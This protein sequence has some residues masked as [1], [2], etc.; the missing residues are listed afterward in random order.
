MIVT[1]IP[2]MEWQSQWTRMKWSNIR[3]SMKYTQADNEFTTLQTRW[4]R[5]KR[6]SFWIIK[7]HEMDGRNEVLH[8]REAHFIRKRRT[9]WQI[10]WLDLSHVII[11]AHIRALLSHI[12]HRTILQFQIN[13]FHQRRASLTESLL[14]TIKINVGRHM[15][16]FS[17]CYSAIAKCPSPKLLLEIGFC[18]L[19]TKALNN[20]FFAQ[21]FH[22]DNDCSSTNDVQ[23]E[24][25]SINWHGM[26][27]PIFFAYVD[28]EFVKDLSYASD[29]QL[30]SIS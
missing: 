1:K 23:W 24:N 20:N 4:E 12:F 30:Y 8:S 18:S 19:Q 7:R 25:S 3:I 15:L 14:R 9:T 22:R 13:T 27:F 29:I 16:W 21:F 17:K 2:R 28:M 11:D 26:F 5:K 6:Q 10:S